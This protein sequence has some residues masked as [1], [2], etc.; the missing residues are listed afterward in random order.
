MVDAVE[1][2]EADEQG[3]SCRCV[4]LLGRKDLLQEERVRQAES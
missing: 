2:A 4:G 1:D 3:R